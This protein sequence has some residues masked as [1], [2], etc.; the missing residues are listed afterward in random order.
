MLFASIP[1]NIDR[2]KCIHHGTQAEKQSIQCL[3]RN[4]SMLLK[5]LITSLITVHFS[6]DGSYPRPNSILNSFW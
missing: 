6:V 2:I 5:T 1:A 4:I 3:M